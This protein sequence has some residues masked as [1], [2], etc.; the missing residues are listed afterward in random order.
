MA[1]NS[2]HVGA[3]VDMCGRR[4]DTRS[5]AR[6]GHGT[7]RRRQ[8]RRGGTRRGEHQ[9]WPGILLLTDITQICHSPWMSSYSQ[10]S[11]NEPQNGC[12]LYAVMN[13][14]CS[15][16]VLESG[17]RNS[18]S[19]KLRDSAPSTRCQQRR[20]LGPW[21]RQRCRR[22]R[23]VTGLTWPPTR[24]GIRVA[25]CSPS[26]QRRLPLQSTEPADYIDG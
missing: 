9:C 5:T 19:H 16:I 18:A 11:I 25:I 2:S 14:T 15:L 4:A 21:R 12:V 24:P 22:R 20:L 7:G 8:R 23:P 26:R 10:F 13:C 3:A 1:A 6:P 17:I